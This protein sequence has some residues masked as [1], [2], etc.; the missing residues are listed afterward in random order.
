[1]HSKNEERRTNNEIIIAGGG[2][3]GLVQALALAHENIPSTIVE[4]GTHA[5]HM[6]A[7]YDG[8]TS[9]LSLGNQIL[10]EKCGA[11]DEMK[12]H[13]EPIKDIRIVDGDSPLFL[14][15]DHED[16]GVKQMGFII[17]NIHFRRALIQA[18]QKN[19]L[20]T[21]LE[22]TTIEKAEPNSH[23]NTLSLSN[24]K[25]IDAKLLIVADGKTSNLREQAGITTRD[26]DYKQTAIICAL[27]HEKHHE[28]IAIE[29]FLPA[30]PFAILPMT[31][32]FHSAIV[33]SER[34][35]LAP[36]F[37]AMDDAAFTAAIT[38]RFT[39][40]LGTLTLASPRWQYPLSLSFATRLYGDRMALVGD[41]A[42]F[43]HPIAGQG[44]N[45]SMKDIAALSRLIAERHA[46]G[47]D[48]GTEDVLKTYS[49]ERKL[50]NLQMIAATDGLNRL[51]SNN[52]KTAKLARRIGL[53]LVQKAPLLKKA[54][55]R[56]AMAVKKPA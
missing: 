41:A 37:M 35:D 7:G 21:V 6:Q 17:E 52:L 43:I 27:A 10:L 18:V 23:L 51:F 47:L 56:H 15:Y 20:I 50:D 49:R 1:M 12:A 40:Y 22:N 19:A 11:W 14:H 55:M 53:G 32:G 30:G 46:V 24:G 2:L 48:I 3:A 4:K 29:K 38:E 36:H 5:L 33:W 44:F 42:H 54:F 26:H 34:S 39:D 45:Q 13:A 31:G 9:F 8:R 25:T 28:N 16:V